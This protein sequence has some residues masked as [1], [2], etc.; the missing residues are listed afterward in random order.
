MA[1]KNILSEESLPQCE[2][3]LLKAPTSVEKSNIYTKMEMIYYYQLGQFDKAYE[4]AKQAFLCNTSD[5]RL[6]MN[7]LLCAE[8]YLKESTKYCSIIVYTIMKNEIGN[9]EGWLENIKDADGIYVLDTGSTDG[10]YEKMLS[11]KEKYPQ[12][13]VDRKIYTEFRFDDARN[14]NLKMVPEM[15][16][17]ICWTIDLDERFVEDWYQ[18]TK[19]AFIK[20]PYFYKL[21]YGY[22]YTHNSDGSVR[23]K[24]LYD[25][26]HRRL[27]A[28]WELPIHEQLLYGELKSIYTDGIVNLGEDIIVHHYQNDKTNRIQ[29]VNLLEKRIDE[30]PFDLEA[31]NHLATEYTTHQIDFQK[32]LDTRFLL[33]SRGIQC[34]SDWK[35]C[36]AGNIAWSLSRTNPAIAKEFYKMAIAFNPKLRTYYLR[37][38]QFLLDNN[39]ITSSNIKE[40]EALLQ[41][42]SKICT[43]QD[44]W[45]DSKENWTWYPFYLLGRCEEI[46][47]KDA[48]F[49][50]QA[51]EAYD[52]IPEWCRQHIDKYLGDN[53]E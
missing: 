37:Y 38:V 53:N 6:T 39:E 19:N 25:K 32:E 10:S 45:K 15:A 3:D 28:Y 24:L 13:H 18:I 16:N 34:N 52:D 4:C 29:Y 49:N 22:A 42:M 8:K 31:I 11:L 48:T 23:E 47:G 43:Q 12:L 1:P 41:T 7:Y 20:H 21:S 51:A 2:L 5:T 14:D 9:I 50:F 44:S 46:V 36:M 35:E 27:G 26:C 40:V 30:N 33:L 17:T